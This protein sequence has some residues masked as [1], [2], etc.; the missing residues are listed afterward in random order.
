MNWVS[1]ILLLTIFS[2]NSTKSSIGTGFNFI[3]FGNGGGFAG[4]ETKYILKED[5]WLSKVINRDTVFLKQIDKKEALAFFTDA[6][7]FKSYNYFKP[8]N[9]YQ[10]IEI[11]SNRIVWGFSKDS[12]SPKVI[13][14]YNNL[15]ILIK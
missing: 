15:S 14:L 2:C 6:F 8:G 13:S 1:F 11:N 10:F 12:L 3:A 7:E 5:G 9:T 4:K